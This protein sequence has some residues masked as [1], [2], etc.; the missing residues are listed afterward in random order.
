MIL[1]AIEI[2]NYKQYAGTHRIEFPEQGMIAIT[3]PNGAGKTTLFE[4]IEW[5]L[6]GPH[7]IRLADIPPHGGVGNTLV[8]LKLQDATS[9]RRYVVERGLRKGATSAEAY[10]EDD[11][12]SPL[13]QGPR[14]VADYVARELIGLPH[15]AFVSTFFTR[16]K[17]LTFFGGHRPTE[18]RVEVARLLGFQTIRDAQEEIAQERNE[19]RREADSRRVQYE[20]EIAGRDLDAEIE[21]ATGAVSEAEALAAMAQTRLTGADAAYVQA[22]DEL[23]RWRG[24]QERDAAHERELLTIAGAVQAAMSRQAA[25]EAELNRLQRLGEERVA[26]AR[27]AGTVETLATR[28]AA[29]ETERE[30]A[31]RL[32]IAH[33]ARRT[34]AD[35]LAAAARSLQ[36]MVAEHEETAAG[37][38]GWFWKNGDEGD[39]C[40]AASRLLLVIAAVDH[41]GARLHAD[42]MQRA[43]D[44][45]ER[46][47]TATKKLDRLRAFRAELTRKRSDLVNGGD[48]AVRLKQAEAEVAS[49]QHALEQ[50]LNDLT[51]ATREREDSEELERIFDERSVNRVC[52]TCSR[53][54]G[55]DEAA[56]LLKTLRGATEQRRAEEQAQQHRETEVRKQVAASERERAAAAALVQDVASLDVRL[57]DG[58]GMIADLE[59][60]HARDLADLR[61]ALDALQ[62]NEPPC[63]EEIDAARA[64]AERAA[65]L[66]ALSG[67]LEQ[68]GQ[69]AAASQDGMYEAE[70]EV[71][72]L[73]EVAYDPEAHGEMQRQLEAARHAAAQVKRI[74][75]EMAQQAGYEM[76]RG[77]ADRELSELDAR[78]REVEAERVAVGFNAEAL[79]AARAAEI[80]AGQEQK[81]ARDAAA[82]A[83]EAHRDAQ[84][85]QRR[86]ID[87]RDRLQRL[88]EEADRR[89][90]EADELDRMYREFGEFDKF[91]ADHVG[92]LLAETTERLLSLVTH[93]KYDRVRFDEN[94]GIEVYD[95]DECF[96][97]EGFSGGERDV[98]ALCARLAMSELVGSSAVRP[99]RFLVL[100]EVFG[101]L[102][103]E[104]RTQL[105]ET[106]G[107]LA[108]SGH[109]QQMFIISHVDDVQLS[110]VMNEAWTIEERDGVSRILRPELLA[111]A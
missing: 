90:R 94:Y 33:K 71:T 100:D 24:L 105:L 63:A 76:T 79:R 93:G 75:I 27:E 95:G 55:D 37:C 59:T 70:S 53:I 39:P 106:L 10:T 34:H 14:Y 87:E 109:F 110:P 12:G 42:A 107:S 6:Y 43:S 83:R 61:S 3:G 5:C 73:G 58:D 1:A 65:T 89:G 9:G 18:R 47:T 28:V 2:E 21:Q 35:Q 23:E 77:E 72:A 103:V 20:R 50:A 104:R 26:L 96:K 92:P 99:P 29:M 64:A 91:V 78:K 74:D 40:Q 62:R 4:A 32:E 45:A 101:S 31:R 57:A 81:T 54:L 60:E 19:A 56:L 66:A 7:S 88:A 108:S 68:I 49:A 97:L 51:K 13:V 17:E 8:R 16:Q 85:S 82:E 25:A 52:P 86:A 15:G 22:R 69:R 102:D 80:E 30:R 111:L 44:L 84:T 67:A 46:A 36:T 38:D 11:P 41:R 98:V 48:P